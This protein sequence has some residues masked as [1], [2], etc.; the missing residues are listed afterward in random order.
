MSFQLRLSHKLLLGEV[1]VAFRQS[2]QHL[3]ITSDFLLS[4][5]T[6]DQASFGEAG[7]IHQSSVWFLAIST[8]HL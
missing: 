6:Y 5:F 7:V 2:S 8:V 1:K 3:L 4:L